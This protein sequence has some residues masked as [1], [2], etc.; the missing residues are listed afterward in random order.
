[1][2]KKK[3]GYWSFL[4]QG[5]LLPCCLSCSMSWEFGLAT[6]RLEAPKIWPDRNVCCPPFLT[7]LASF[8]RNYV[9]LSF[10]WLSLGMAVDF[11]RVVIFCIL[12][13]VPSCVHKV[14]QYCQ[15]YFLF[16]RAEKL[17]RYLK[18]LRKII[19]SSF[20]FTS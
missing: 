8:Q 12:C 3:N 11:G 14:V 20:A 10:F 13:G 7:T 2:A 16:V 4:S 19:L 1:M 6:L 17:T 15:Q 9:N 18:G 5:Q